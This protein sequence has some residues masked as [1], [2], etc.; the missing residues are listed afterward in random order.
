A[1][2]A[3]EHAPARRGPSMEGREGDPAEDGSAK[4]ARKTITLTE[5]ELQARVQAALLDAARRPVPPALQETFTPNDPVHGL[6]HLPAIVKAVVDTNIFQRM[7]QIKQLGICHYVYPGAV[8]TRFF[9]SIGTAFLALL[10]KGLRHRQPELGVTD[11]EAVC[12]LLAAL[13]HDS[14]G[15]KS[16]LAHKAY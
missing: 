4:R 15:P 10:I 8:H 6:M 5:E 12:V 14:G 1:T 9:H 7:R 2:G 3:R 13:C 16:T 11:R